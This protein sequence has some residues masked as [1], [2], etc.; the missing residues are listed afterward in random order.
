MSTFRPQ[1][2]PFDLPCSCPCPLDGHQ[3]HR[4]GDSDRSLA[5]YLRRRPCSG[6]RQRGRVDKNAERQIHGRQIALAEHPASMQLS[7]G[8]GGPELTGR[9]RKGWQA[10]GR[11]RAW[12][13][14][15]ADE[16]HRA[17]TGSM[18]R[19]APW[20]R[21]P[22]ADRGRTSTWK[23]SSASRWSSSPRSRSSASSA[24]SARTNPP[25]VDL[26]LR[27]P[28]ARPDRRRPSSRPTSLRPPSPPGTRRPRRRRT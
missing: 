24:S 19:P 17:T 2:A 25:R 13:S 22:L 5:G 26:S 28:T 16:L 6:R 14:A 20:A 3:N 23:R 18:I 7:R 1:E 21:C 9:R 4:P 10:L 11:G 12:R 8:R 27:G 15:F